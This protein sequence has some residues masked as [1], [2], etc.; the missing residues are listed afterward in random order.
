MILERIFQFYPSLVSCR[1]SIRRRCSWTAPVSGC[2]A[3]Q[4][5]VYVEE[6]TICE[7]LLKPGP[8]DPVPSSGLP[9]ILTTETFSPLPPARFCLALLVTPLSQATRD[10]GGEEVMLGA[11][12]LYF[13]LTCGGRCRA[14]QLATNLRFMDTNI[15]HP[16]MDPLTN[17]ISS[18]GNQST[19]SLHQRSHPSCI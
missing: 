19:R 6:F 13:C 14:V 18:K 9:L 15:H 8:V 7:T 5:P 11:Y 3:A 12:I 2:T 4:K 17:I 10:S 16:Y 1:T